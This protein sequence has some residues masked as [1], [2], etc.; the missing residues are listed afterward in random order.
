MSRSDVL[1]ALLDELADRVAD[2][3]AS[4]LSA[5][6]ELVGEKE[7]L[8]L[9]GTKD[10]VRRLIKSGELDGSLPGQKIVVKR[11]S[12]TAYLDTK[13]PPA[14]AKQETP[15]PA[16]EDDEDRELLAQVGLRVAPARRRGYGGRRA[17]S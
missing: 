1:E 10:K 15:A 7:L 11:A 5:A 13:K 8:E 14:K 3:L 4:K 9:L 12:L 16:N 17:A 2:R 6:A